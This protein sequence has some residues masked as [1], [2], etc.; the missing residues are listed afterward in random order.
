MATWDFDVRTHRVIWSAT[1]F[2]ILGCEPIPGEASAT[3]WENCVHPDDLKQ[4]MQAAKTARQTRSLYSP[5]YRIIRADNGEIRW[6][7]AFGRYLYDAAGEAV[8]FIG[9]LF[10]ATDRK[11]AELA[12]QES[13]QTVRRQLLEIESL[14]QTTPVGLAVLDTD[15]RFV[16]INQR[17]AQMNG[18]A[19]EMHTGRTLREI[20]PEW[21]DTAEPLLGHL[22]DTGQPIRNFELTGATRDQPTV[23]RTWLHNWWPLRDRGGE[24]VGIHI[25]VQE[26]TDRKMAELALQESYNRFQLATTAIDGLV[27]EW[28]LAANSVYRSEGLSSIVGVRPDDAPTTPEW[29]RERIHPADVARL[30]PTRESLLTTGDRYQVEYRVRHEDGRWIDV[31]ER[32][33]LIRNQQG[34]VTKI[35]GFTSNITQR[36]QAEAAL[37]DRETHLE[38]ILD[39][40]KDYAIFTQD[41]DGHVTSWNAGAERVLG[42]TESEIVGQ[43][44]R[45]IFTPED[46]AAGKPELEMHIALTQGKA[47]NERWHVRKDGSRFWG[48]GTGD[49]PARRSRRGARFPEN[50]AGQNRA[51]ANRRSTAAKRKSLPHSRR[52]RP[53]INV[54]QHR[55]R[56]VRVLQPTLEKLHGDDARIAAGCAGAA[57]ISS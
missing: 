38:L 43:H 25:V 6:L 46:S 22:L 57:I 30:Q 13:E 1:H 55:R 26:I 50:H 19:L 48:S 11:K 17:F 40:A 7:S 8:R 32:G 2:S 41:L 42:Y 53:G 33:C 45:L 23:V 14:Y 54:D 39:S 47:V 21:A 18:L 10:D 24:I 31:W 3:V 29:W 20:V 27:F 36:K 44:G 9:V 16:R 51:P 49:A 35:V 5:E 28:D 15:L 37:R 56:Q 34:E 4:V 12:L 52:W